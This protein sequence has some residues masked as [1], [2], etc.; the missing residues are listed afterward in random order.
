MDDD[1]YG[2]RG[3]GDRRRSVGGYKLHAGTP[4]YEQCVSLSFF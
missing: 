3:R 1:H 4:P 2:L